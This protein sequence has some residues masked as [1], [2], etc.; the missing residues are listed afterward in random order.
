MK[1]GRPLT[2]GEPMDYVL[3]V[4]LTARMAAAI[5]ARRGRLSR[6]QWARNQIKK[7]LE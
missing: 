5:D 2:E 3:R 1:K 4:R 6:A 7:G